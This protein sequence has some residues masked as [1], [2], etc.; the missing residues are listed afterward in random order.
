MRARKFKTVRKSALA[1]L[2]VVLSALT[3]LGFAGNFYYDIILNAKVDRTT[4]FADYLQSRGVTAFWSEYDA[5]TV[6]WLEDSSCEAYITADDGVRLHACKVENPEAQGRW[7]LIFHGYGGN[8]TQMCAEA[9]SFYQMGYSLLIPDMRGCGQSGGNAMGM[10]WLDRLDVIS[11]ANSLASVEPDCK[12]LLYGVSMGAAAV[13]AATGESLPRNVR[14]AV[15]DCGYSSVQDEF[16]GLLKGYF[17][18][19]EF[20]VLCA[21]EAVTYFRAGYTFSGASAVEQVKKSSTPTLF[22]HG[23]GDEFVP[24]E[25]LDKVYSA[26]ACPKEKLV[27]NG[28]GHV[29]SFTK[30]PKLYLCAVEVFAEKY[31]EQ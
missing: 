29:G 26:A 24:F 14:A 28:A 16:S 6:Q 31:A 13:M 12:I 9:R 3:G 10:G 2:S 8:G 15:A 20:P 23:S 18:I 1:F 5:D 25:M 7:A 4:L 21:A 11:W 22:I 30:N 27:I 17:G 19:D